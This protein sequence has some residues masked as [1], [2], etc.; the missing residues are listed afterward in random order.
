MFVPRSI[1]A[2]FFFMNNNEVFYSDFSITV[3]ILNVLTLLKKANKY[4]D[5]SV[6]LVNVNDIFFYILL[7]A[8]ASV[9]ILTFYNFS[10]G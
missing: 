3:N 6:N 4:S 5:L 10:F 1:T 7:S 9:S 8:K 2:N